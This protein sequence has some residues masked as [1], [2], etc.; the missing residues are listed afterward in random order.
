MEIV[1]RAIQVRRHDCNIVRTVLEIVAFAHF[2]P[3]NLRYR[4]F[5]VG[6]FQRR[7]Q[8]GV[9]LHRLG[10]IFRINAGRAEEEQFLD[11]VAVGVADYVA[12]HLHVLHDEVGPVERIGHDAAHESGRKYHSVRTFLVK[13]LLDGILVREVKFLMRASHEIGISALLEIV[14]NRRA[15]QSA[16]AGNVNFAILVQHCQCLLGVLRSLPFL[17]LFHPADA[18]AQ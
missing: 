6:V 2:Q 15:H 1:I 8:K 9:F 7:G 13:E 16:M 11:S 10:S 17:H 14:P 12:L 4:I 18:M 5:L 3:G